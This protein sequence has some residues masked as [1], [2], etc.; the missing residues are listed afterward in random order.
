[1]NPNKNFGRVLSG[2]AGRAVR[3]LRSL[4]DVSRVPDQVISWALVDL[5]R[6]LHEAARQMDAGVSEASVGKALRLWGPDTRPVLETARR[7]GGVRASRLFDAAM[8]TD[9][10]L[11]SGRSGDGPRTLEGL[12]VLLAD[13]CR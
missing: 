8:K 9:E 12:A 6:K 13:S 3:T 1:M 7:L 10:G 5:G 2:D 11:K 4:K